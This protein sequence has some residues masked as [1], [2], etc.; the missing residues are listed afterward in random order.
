ME[1]IKPLLVLLLRKMYWLIYNR[2]VADT[3]NDKNYSSLIQSCIHFMYD[4]CWYHQWHAVAIVMQNKAI[5]SIYKQRVN[6][7]LVDESS[8]LNP[9]ILVSMN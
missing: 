2:E 3:N 5:N 1:N 9:K 8:T 7:V 6:S 4:R